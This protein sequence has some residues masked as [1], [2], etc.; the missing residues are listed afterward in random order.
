MKSLKTSSYAERRLQSKYVGNL[1]EKAFVDACLLQDWIVMKG[2]RAQDI[3]DH[4][5]YIVTTKTETFS[6]DVKTAQDQ[7]LIWIEIKNVNGALGWLYGKAD[8]IA[9]YTSVLMKI[10]MVDRE[11]LKEYVHKNTIKELRPKGEALHHLYQRAGRR[12]ILT[13]IP[14]AALFTFAS[15]NIIRHEPI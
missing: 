12:D 3:H 8:R 5:D 11:E 13:Q 6:V 4:V 7:E 15:L 14:L 10:I 1:S 9:F 2:S